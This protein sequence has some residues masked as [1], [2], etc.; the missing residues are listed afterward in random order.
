MRRRA[1][2]LLATMGVALLVAGGG[3]FAAAITCTTNPCVGTRDGDVITGTDSEETI[4]AR[5]GDDQVSGLG[6]RDKL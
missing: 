4:K 3:A 1:V 6:R 5:A 2:L